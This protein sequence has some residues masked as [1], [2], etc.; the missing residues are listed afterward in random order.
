MSTSQLLLLA[1]L[2]VKL[3]PFNKVS[4]FGRKADIGLDMALCMCTEVVG[5]SPADLDLVSLPNDYATGNLEFLRD[6]LGKPKQKSSCAN[7]TTKSA[8]A[9]N[10]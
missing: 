3:I 8:R 1:T 2:A 4:G 10:R 7:L 5:L 6:H 9:L